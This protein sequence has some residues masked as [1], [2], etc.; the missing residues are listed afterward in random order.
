MHHHVNIP[1]I[2]FPYTAYPITTNSSLTFSTYF[3][4]NKKFVYLKYRY[5]NTSKFNI[6]QTTFYS[7]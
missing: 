2:K 7:I 3:K 4:H 5:K 1:S 6:P